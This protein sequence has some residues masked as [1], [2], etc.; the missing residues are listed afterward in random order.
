VYEAEIWRPE[1]MTDQKIKILLVCMGNIC[2]SPTAHGVLEQKINDAGLGH[3]VEIDSAG[4]YGAH[5]GELPDERS[6]KIAETRGYDLT[7]IRSRQVVKNDFNYFDYIL[8]MDKANF[9]DLIYKSTAENEHKIAM[10][11]EYSSQNFSDVPDPYYGG[12][13]GFENVLDMIEDASNGLISHLNF[14]LSTP[15]T[16]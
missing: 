12:P 14:I 16:A 15:K 7:H 6:T 9:N 5:I 8:A 11:L 13:S 10:F 2:R 4:T 3:L 1:D